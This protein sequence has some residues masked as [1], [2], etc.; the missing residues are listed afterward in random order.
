M[1]IECKKCGLLDSSN[2]YPSVLKAINKGWA[3]DNSCK[4]CTGKTAKLYM[5]KLQ[6]LARIGRA[7]IREDIKLKEL[8]YQEI[9]GTTTPPWESE[10]I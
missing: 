4:I 1:Q 10:K 9:Y 2:F 7:A 6:V 8:Y 5:K 3:G